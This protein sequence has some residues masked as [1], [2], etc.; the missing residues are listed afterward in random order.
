[1]GAIGSGKCLARGTGVL[2]FDGRVRNVEDIKVDDVLMGDDSTPRRVRGVT[3]GEGE[4]YEIVPRKGVSFTVNAHHILSLKRTNRRNRHGNNSSLNGKIIDISV[5]DYLTKSRYFKNMTKLYRVGVKFRFQPVAIDPYFLGLWLGDGNSHNVGITTMDVEIVRSVYQIAKR[6][7]LGVT[8]NCNRHKTCPTYTITTQKATGGHRRNSLLEKFRSY[9]LLKNKHIPFEYKANNREIRLRLLAGLIDTDGDKTDN[10]LSI[11]TK[12]PVLAEDILYLV[13]SLGLAGYVNK[14]TILFNRRR[15]TYYRVSISGDLSQIPCQLER[16]RCRP[17]KQKKSVLV[18]QFRIKPRGQ[19]QYYG[20]D[21]DDNH[22]FL[23]SDFTVTHNSF[24]SSVSMVYLV[25][26]LGCL[27]DPQAYFHLAPKSGIHLM[28]MSSNEKQALKVIFSEIKARVDTCKWFKENFPYDPQIT[29]EL[30]FPDNITA[31]PGNSADTFFE[32]YNI[33]GGVLDEGDSHI[34]TPEKDFAEEGYNA[35]KNRLRS[36]FGEKGL[37]IIIGSPKSEDGFM[38]RKYNEAEGSPRIY[39]AW[40]PYWESPSA[41]IKYSGDVFEFRG[42]KIPIEHKPDFDRNPERALRDIA[43]MPSSAEEAFYVMQDRID[44]WA[45][46]LSQA[47]PFGGDPDKRPA[48]IDD[49]PYQALSSPQEIACVI[50]IDLGLN[51]ERGDACG[52]SLGYIKEI[53]EIAG[54]MLPVIEMP[55][56]ERIVAPPGGEIQ[57]SEVRKRIY[58]LKDLGFNI[59]LVTYDGWQSAESIQ[60]LK[61]RGIMADTFSVD[62]D[63]AAHDTLK[64]AIYDRRINGAFPPMLLTELKKLQRISGDRVDHPVNGSKDV[65][66]SVAG[67]VFHLHD[68]MRQFRPK[69]IIFQSH[70]GGERLTKPVGH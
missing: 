29:S 8:L 28:F 30:R 58:R 26:T 25:Y 52:F 60:E 40:I 48:N 64:Q 53:K 24:L 56:V 49:S 45:T 34:H 65:A 37:V 13:R 41:S 54:E 7:G 68:K 57:I 9:N 36:R 23:L 47:F 62:R 63:T 44:L 70:L 10:C 46:S 35:I 61:R 50:H 14:K 6:M 17:R 43:A 38:M 33:F 51:K 31:I 18:T 42:I 21:L 16:R 5:E 4:M 27:L 15:L 66:D 55:V 1:M 39:R 3:R 59:R 12:Y 20:F 67:V 11:T 22:R 2:M 32:G 69:D 19:G